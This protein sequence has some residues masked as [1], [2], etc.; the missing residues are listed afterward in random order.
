MAIFGA[1]GYELD[2]TKL[3]DRQREEIKQQIAFFKEHRNLLQFGAFYRLKSPFAGN[4][5]GWMVVSPDK[6]QAI[7]LEC[8]ILT[9][10]NAPCRRLKL[11]GLDPHALYAVNGENPRYGDEL[12]QAGLVTTDSTSGRS[13]QPEPAQGDFSCRLFYLEAE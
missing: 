7:A 10:A 4:I 9:Q 5:A 12:M 8:K 13:G 11:A 2:V 3:P 1:F 6:T